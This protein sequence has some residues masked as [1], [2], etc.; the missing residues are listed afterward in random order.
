VLIL[1]HGLG[2]SHTS[3]T[4]FARSISLPETVCISVRGLSPL[5]FDIGGNHW[6][7]DV[8]IDQATGGIDIDAGFTRSVNAIVEDVIRTTLLGKCGYR[9]KEVLL[10]GFGQGGYAA[11]NCAFAMNEELGGIVAIGGVLP[12]TV[13]ISDTKNGTPILLCKGNR[14]SVVQEE[15]IDKMKRAFSYIEVKEWSK[16]GDGMPSNREEMLPL[17]QFFARRLRSVHGVPAGAVELS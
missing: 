11:L 8:V 12:C 1:L 5:P 6:G 17:M 16:T 3:F 9:A 13:S 14:K 7:D 10:F 15:D 2:D 4:K